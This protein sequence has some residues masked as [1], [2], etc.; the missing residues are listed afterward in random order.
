MINKIDD[1][2]MKKYEVS[3][4]RAHKI[5]E[6]LGAMMTAAQKNAIAKSASV[7]VTSY[8][9]DEQ[10]SAIEKSAKEAIEAAAFFEQLSKTHKSVRVKISDANTAHGIS[11]LL[12]EIESNKRIASL[13]TQLSETGPDV[14]TI[15]TESLKSYQ[16]QADS[17]G[18]IYGNTRGVMVTSILRS[19]AEVF[20]KHK[21][22]LDR[23]NYALTNILADLNGNKIEIQVPLRLA[24]DLGL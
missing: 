1:G 22:M 19:D 7:R 24:P 3:L 14:N 11:A 18:G 10:I 9:G 17:T 20:A 16:P 2:V 5:T 13:A 12:A 4:A 8:T 6:R 23:L 15:N 21:E